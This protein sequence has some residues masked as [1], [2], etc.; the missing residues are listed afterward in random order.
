MSS[1]SLPQSLRH[2]A[3]GRRKPD[4]PEPLGNPEAVAVDFLP[5]GGKHFSFPLL[6]SSDHEGQ[7]LGRGWQ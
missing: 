1:G 4:E 7:S 3:L 6:T 5:Q 2:P